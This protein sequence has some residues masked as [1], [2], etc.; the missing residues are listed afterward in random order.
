MDPSGPRSRQAR[1]ERTA[2]CS[3]PRARLARL[4]AGSAPAGETGRS[5]RAPPPVRTT[6]ARRPGDRAAPP[7]VRRTAAQVRDDS[8]AEVCRNLLQLGERLLLPPLQTHHASQPHTGLVEGRVV[9][10]RLREEPLGL[11][12]VQAGAFDVERFP[13]A[14]PRRFDHGLHLWRGEHF[15]QTAARE[16]HERVARKEPARAREMDEPIRVVGTSRRGAPPPRGTTALRSGGEREKAAAC[17]AARGRTRD[18]S[19]DCRRR[20]CF[21]R[22]TPRR[23]VP[24]RRSATWHGWAPATRYRGAAAHLRSAR[25]PGAASGG[26]GAAYRP[27]SAEDHRPTSRAG[28]SAAPGMWRSTACSH[29]A[30]SRDWGAD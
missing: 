4:P 8:V 24:R 26:A 16:E 10:Q 23:P 5:E 14:Q 3:R 12:Q 29:W 21:R 11:T 27:R 19:Q 13:V 20:P 22:S 28:P 15:V 25:A 30:L 18:A 9:L 7:S 2:R 6:C 1:Q 17:R